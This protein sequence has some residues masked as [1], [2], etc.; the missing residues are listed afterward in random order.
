MRSESPPSQDV[1]QEALS[2]D[3]WVSLGV[4]TSMARES[5]GLKVAQHAKSISGL[6]IPRALSGS[7][8][9]TRLLGVEHEPPIL[10][11]VEP[12][13]FRNAYHRGYQ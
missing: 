12:F 11:L 7:P 13:V 3:F 8:A 9:S 6:S 1:I 10:R 4:Q 5:H 2:V